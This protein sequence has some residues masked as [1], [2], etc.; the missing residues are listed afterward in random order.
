MRV[1][2]ML[3]A[4]ACSTLAVGTAVADPQGLSQAAT[5]TMDR[6]RV[7]FQRSMFSRSRK[8]APPTTVSVKTNEPEVKPA[9]EPSR[10]ADPADRY[11]FVGVSI[12][13]DETIAFFEDQDDATIQRVT[14][15]AMLGERKIS[16][17]TLD[18]VEST[19]GDK[20]MRIEVGQRLSGSDVPPIVRSV[21]TVPLTSPSTKVDSPTPRPG[22][23]AA[24]DPASL[25]IIERLRLRRQQE[26]G[27]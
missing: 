17:I 27:Q 12:I 8:P 3:I 25:S 13:G 21:P 7:V 11:L 26:L 20:S 22:P 10:P 23:A 15:G 2:D 4:V 16:T 14:S 5:P 6:Y 19:R 9:A 24:P 1:H 18:S